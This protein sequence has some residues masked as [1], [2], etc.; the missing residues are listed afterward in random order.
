M[1]H[2]NLLLVKQKQTYSLIQ[3]ALLL[4]LYFEK[5]LKTSLVVFVL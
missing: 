1:L 4:L 3:L 2:K 5:Q